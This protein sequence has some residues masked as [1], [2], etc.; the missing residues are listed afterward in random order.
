[1]VVAQKIH[2][3]SYSFLLLL[4]LIYSWRV[5]C[6]DDNNDVMMIACVNVYVVRVLNIACFE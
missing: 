5:V 3:A 6:G 2:H 1:L 4:L